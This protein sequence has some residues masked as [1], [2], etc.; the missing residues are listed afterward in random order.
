MSGRDPSIGCVPE[1][2]PDVPYS[3]ANFFIIGILSRPTSAVVSEVSN[4]LEISSCKLLKAPWKSVDTPCSTHNC[5]DAPHSLSENTD[6]RH[7]VM[8]FVGVDSEVLQDS[9]QETFGLRHYAQVVKSPAD[10]PKFPG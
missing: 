5:L 8:N 3:L 2:Y 6:L 9:R 7:K 4:K 10:F 1:F